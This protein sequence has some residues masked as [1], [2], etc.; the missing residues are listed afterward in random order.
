MV[1]VYRN[2]ELRILFFGLELIDL[3]VLAILFVVIFNASDHLIVNLL[4]MISAYC[5]LRLFKQDKPAG[6]TLHLARFLLSEQDGHVQLEYKGN[7]HER[8]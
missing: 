2:I 5:G 8:R 7:R 3:L 4:V 6:Y 1:K